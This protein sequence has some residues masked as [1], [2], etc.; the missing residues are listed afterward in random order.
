MRDIECKPKNRICAS[1]SLIYK[2]LI[3]TMKIYTISF[4][5]HKKNSICR[6]RLFCHCK[7]S[8]IMSK[9]GLGY[10]EGPLSWYMLFLVLNPAHWPYKLFPRQ[11][12][13]SR[14]HTSIS[15]VNYGDVLPPRGLYLEVLSC[16][17]S[18]AVDYVLIMMDNHFFCFFSLLFVLPMLSCCRERN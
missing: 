4:E 9:R 2:T 1:Y 3:Y 10:R 13:S 17:S 18:L 16:L 7:V 14:F 11:L 12:A 6:L 5:S 8:I 15:F